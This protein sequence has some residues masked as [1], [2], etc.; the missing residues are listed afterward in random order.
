MKIIITGK[1]GQ[2]G[3]SL[4]KQLGSYNDI[5]P[6][7]RNDLDLSTPD[8]II[9]ALDKIQPDI[10]VNSAAYTAV[11]KA[12][13]DSDTAMAV[14]YEAVARMADYC[15]SKDILF[16]HYS[17][18]YV[19]DGQKNGRYSELDSPN[20]LSIYG[21]SK[22]YGE[23]AVLGS[24]CPHMIFRTSWVYSNHGKNFANTILNLARERRQLTIVNDQIGCP[25][26]TDTIAT[27][28][29]YCLDRYLAAD[30]AT[31]EKFHG[32]YNLTETGTTTWFEFAKFLIEGVIYRGVDLA[33]SS[34]QVNPISTASYGATAPRPL[35]STLDCTKIDK[36]FDLTL[37]SWQVAANDFLDDWVKRNSS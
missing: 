7:G 29:A 15:A 8:T 14:N 25:T 11:D 18:D 24:T 32:L 35:N 16:I 13:T 20:P 5:I 23:D 31:Q 6:M 2:L 28:T 10:L 30:S 22:R 4:V 9:S 17:T 34:D 37:S 26:N 36:T 3:T 27:A 33:C 21:Q 12:E 1:N 19:F